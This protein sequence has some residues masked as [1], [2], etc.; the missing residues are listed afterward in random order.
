MYSR[1]AT[2]APAGITSIDPKP[3]KIGGFCVSS[4][5]TAAT[6]QRNETE[7]SALADEDGQDEAI[8]SAS[9][10]MVLDRTYGGGGIFMEM[11]GCADSVRRIVRNAG[12]ETVPKRLRTST[13]MKYDLPTAS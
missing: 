1:L 2:S 9:R 7:D 3:C 11:S 12:F 5:A 13:E 10:Y 8:P 4:T 6:V